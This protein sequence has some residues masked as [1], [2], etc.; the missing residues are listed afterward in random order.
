MIWQLVVELN[1]HIHHTFPEE[2]CIAQSHVDP[3][4]F[5]VL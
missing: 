5:R 3:F 2:V 4:F 1:S